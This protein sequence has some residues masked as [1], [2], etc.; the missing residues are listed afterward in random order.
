MADEIGGQFGQPI[1]ATLRPAVFDRHILSLDVA[2]F[3]KPLAERGQTRCKRAGLLAAQKT[4][5]RHRL[6]LRAQCARH[7]YRAAHQEQQFA[8]P[9]SATSSARGRIA[10]GEGRLPRHDEPR[11]N[12]RT[13]LYHKKLSRD[14]PLVS[15]PLCKLRA[16]D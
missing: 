1:K 12:S 10:D 6:L 3:A 8:P 14:A 5:D 15:M 11:S 16:V 7:N 4:D 9:H 13:E 2:G